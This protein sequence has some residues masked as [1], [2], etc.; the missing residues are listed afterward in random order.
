MACAQFLRDSQARLRKPL[1]VIWSTKEPR[2][3]AGLSRQGLS[4]FGVQCPIQLSAYTA[5]TAAVCALLGS[6]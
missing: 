3:S 6:S 5:M 4:A 2:L 1:N